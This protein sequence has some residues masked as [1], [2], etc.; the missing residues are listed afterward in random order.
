MDS[1]TTVEPAHALKAA[2]IA[3]DSDALVIAGLKRERDELHNR[4]HD[5]AVKMRPL[6]E[7]TISE[8]WQLLQ[9]ADEPSILA[10]ARAVEKAH[11]I[12]A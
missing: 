8:L 3:A 7:A 11:G 10:L 9:L 2:L 1:T 12:D 4:L 5:Q 6:S